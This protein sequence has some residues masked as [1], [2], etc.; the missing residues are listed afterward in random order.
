M[1]MRERFLS[2]GV[3]ELLTTRGY[4]LSPKQ[5]ISLHFRCLVREHKFSKSVSLHRQFI[6]RKRKNSFFVFSQCYMFTICVI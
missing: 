1:Y 2:R 3:A 5:Q 6:E 4:I